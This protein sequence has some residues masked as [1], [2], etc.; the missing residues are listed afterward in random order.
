AGCDVRPSLANAPHELRVV[1]ETIVEPVFLV[2]EPN[3]DTGRPTMASDHDLFRLGQPEI[4]GEVI[5][6]LRQ[7]HP[8]G[9]G[10]PGCRATLAPRP[11]R[12]S[13]GRGL[14]CR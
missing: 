6:H 14:P 10:Y 13:R 5:L 8:A 7:R 12:R 2:T 1:G 11:S 4:A 9:L 3:Q